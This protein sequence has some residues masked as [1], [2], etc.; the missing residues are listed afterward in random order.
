MNR[1]HWIEVVACLMLATMADAANEGLT[2]LPD[3]G[4]FARKPA[5]QPAPPSLETLQPIQKRALFK[6]PPVQTETTFLLA[7]G[8]CAVVVFSF[9]MTG[10]FAL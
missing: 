10:G 5:R 6:P 8:L 3:T 1:K 2:H 7:A 4:L 9:I